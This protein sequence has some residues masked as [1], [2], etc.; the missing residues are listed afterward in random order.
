MFFFYTYPYKFANTMNSAFGDHLTEKG[1][2]LFHHPSFVRSCRAV[3]NTML[4][5]TN[6]KSQDLGIELKGSSIQYPICSLKI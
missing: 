1:C 2:V 5:Q 4:Q 6:I 3:Y